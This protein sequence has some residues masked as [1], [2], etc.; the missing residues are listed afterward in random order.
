MLMRVL[1]MSVT[2]LY[3][4]FSYLKKNTGSQGGHHPGCPATQ[5]YHGGSVLTMIC[6]QPR[7]APFELAPFVRPTIV[8]DGNIHATIASADY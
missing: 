6:R 7:Q 4:T 3:L 5:S 2:L 1:Y 8:N